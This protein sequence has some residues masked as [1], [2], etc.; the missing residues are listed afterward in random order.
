MFYLSSSINEDRFFALMLV[1]TETTPEWF[2]KIKRA[3][4]AWDTRGIDAFAYIRPLANG[5]KIIVPI[6]ILSASKK[7]WKYNKQQPGNLEAGVV[8]IVVS[9]KRTEEFIRQQ[10]FERLEGVRD[11]GMRFDE[12]L[13]RRMDRPLNDRARQIK[14][15][16]RAS[17]KNSA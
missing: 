10:L 2:I 7:R 4:P 5:R 9:A 6:Q 8:T 13:K 11:A 15:Y 16:L 12:F 1:R 14:T 3:N 17:R